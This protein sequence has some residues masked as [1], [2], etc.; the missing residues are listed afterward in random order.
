[1]DRLWCKECND[2]PVDEDEPICSRCLR[3]KKRFARIE[4]NKETG[5]L[6]PFFIV[7]IGTSRIYGGPEE[8]GWWD[9]RS[10]IIDVAQVY[11]PRHGIRVAKKF[12]EENPQPKYGIY[13]CAN[14][15]EPEI[16]IRAYNK[17]EDWDWVYE[18]EALRYC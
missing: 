14:R 17:P 15:G 12:R 13:S 9:N 16:S 1:M 3:K 11:G 10:E 2:W 18:Q 4:R 5:S 7:V 8:G 6:E